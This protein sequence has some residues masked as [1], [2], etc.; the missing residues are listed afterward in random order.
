MT[1][2]G[3]SPNL[4]KIVLAILE[5]NRLFPDVG[6]SYIAAH[7]TGG[8]TAGEYLGLTGKRISTSSDALFVVLGTNYVPSDKLKKTIWSAHFLSFCQSILG[9]I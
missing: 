7:S 8:G 2:Q 4:S 1:L 3:S 6:F 5:R 9:G